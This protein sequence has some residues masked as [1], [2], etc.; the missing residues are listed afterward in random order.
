MLN[1]THI[2]H[3]LTGIKSIVLLQYL[4][5]NPRK[6]EYIY[7]THETIKHIM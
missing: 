6:F 3:V 2:F 4:S 7:L 5:Y 1:F